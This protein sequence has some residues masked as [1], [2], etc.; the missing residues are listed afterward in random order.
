[1]I[2]K[3]KRYIEQN[4]LFSREDKIILAISGGADSVCLMH[5]LIELGVYFE[6][7][8]CNFNLRGKESDNDESFVKSLALNYKL[9]LHSKS[10]DTYA[11]SVKEQVSIQM[12]ARELRY[13]WFDK[14]LYSENA[15]YIAIAHHQD[16]SLETF[17]IN[18]IRGTG[19]S[20]LRGILSKHNAVVRPLLAVNRADIESYM[21]RNKYLYREDSSNQSTKYIRNSI[22]LKL[23]PVLKDINSSALL[24]IK[25]SISILSDT[26]LIF[27]NHINSVRSQLLEN[28]G[29][30]L[31]ISIK[32]L[33]E[34]SPLKSYLFEILKPFGFYQI[35]DI[36]IALEGRSGIR[37]F[38]KSHCLLI[39]RSKIFITNNTID[40]DFSLTINR[41]DNEVVLSSHRICFSFS[42]EVIFD[43]K[44]NVAH[45]DFDELEFPLLLRRWKKGDKFIPLGMKNF[46]KISDF[47]IDNKFS[48]IQKKEQWILC[49]GGEI[50]W[51]VG[52]RI[53][54]RFKVKS[55]T[56]NL[57][58]AELLDVN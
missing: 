47:F 16:D 12:A 26:S 2:E 46:K 44:K 52:A 35:H 19:I 51:L 39:D 40:D 30:V 22:R 21:L 58:I 11:Y 14:L 33:K 56:K 28:E 25:N 7:A 3:V 38:S 20:G 6:L 42:K 5:I 50:V 34:L 15:K 57:Y 45:L 23:L 24:N 29:G 18:L 10:F 4:N 32:K 53:D 41:S 48:I 49:S 31:S 13:E 43:Q 37:F 54:E 1:M 27:N 55:T 36:S 17:F 8:H 9:A